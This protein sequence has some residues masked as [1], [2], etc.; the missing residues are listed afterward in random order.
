MLIFDEATSA[1]DAESEYQVQGAIDELIN[2]TKITI[3]VIAHKLATIKNFKKIA[4]FESG[5]II[6][7]GNH[8]SLMKTCSLYN[9]LVQ[10]QH[11][12]NQTSSSI[13][14]A[15]T[16]PGIQSSKIK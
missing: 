13:K 6:A 9:N 12:T 14:K 3:I 5:Q 2:K 1:L 15:S 7:M 11:I 8:D 4:I 16:D 10:L